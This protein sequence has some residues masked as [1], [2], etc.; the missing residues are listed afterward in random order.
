MTDEIDDAFDVLEQ[1]D[2]VDAA[3]DTIETSV[4]QETPTTGA[5]EID[6][7]VQQRD[8]PE[9]DHPDVR[10]ACRFCEQE[11][12]TI[13]AER[14]HHCHG[15]DTS[16][17][18][19]VDAGDVIDPGAH[20]FTGKFL[21]VPG[22]GD[23]RGNQ[24]GTAPYFAIVSQFDRCLDEGD[25]DEIGTLEAAGNSWVLN[26]G[27]DKVKFWK[28]SIGT[29]PTDSGDRY[30]EYNIGLVVPDSVREK[31]VNFQ[32]RIA[33]PNLTHY[34][35]G[36]PI[37]SLPDDLPEGVRVEISSSNIEPAETF[38][39]LRQLVDAMNIDPS[40]F[41]EDNL[42]QWSRVVNFALYVRIMRAISED[43]IVSR[44]GL[45]DRLSSF[46]SVRSG[47]GEYKWD[48]EEIIGHRNAAAFNPTSLEK[49]YSN[50]RVGKLLK[51]YHPKNP[52]SQGSSDPLSHPKLEVQ[53]STEY[54]DDNTVP[55]SDPD[56]FDFQDLRHELDEFLIFALN[57]AG[58]P[59]EADHETY[60]GD[61]YWSVETA[62]RGI[63]VHADKTDDVREHEE[64][65]ATYLLASDEI[66]PSQRAVLQAIADG[67][68]QMDRHEIAA[69]SDTST[70]TVQRTYEACAGVIE[71]VGRGMYYLADDVVREKIS[72]LLNGLESATEW[73]E[74]GIDAI[75]ENNAEIDEN[76]PIRRWA[77]NHGV[78]FNEDYSGNI[79][80]D[81]AGPRGLVEIRRLL[82]AGLEAA[83]ST[84]SKTAA[85][86][87]DSTVIFRDL[88][89]D[90][91]ERRAFT[92]VGAGM[93]ILGAED[94]DR[95]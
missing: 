21:F 24:D 55:W 56:Q 16:T 4:E 23:L 95:V 65:R 75:A 68:R 14:R 42:H 48:N 84:G 52:R 26:H 8:G 27:D 1:A 40:Y 13:V 91:R 79:E 76:S 80:L 32:F 6:G 34:E 57:S 89:G 67:G 72:Q 87:A 71:R 46:S 38:E 82:R 73:V 59:L 64:D 29:R 63:S 11:F 3:D 12:R 50:H 58:L 33:A 7:S 10:S 25:G 81:I 74:Q 86:F 62:Q 49:F 93:K 22:L 15:R 51:S 39:V 28:G 60:V 37:G 90:R 31:K 70:S 88:D 30:Y 47:R 78:R 5:D 69:E 20:E 92:R 35:S 54:S 66:T 36:D 94:V 2:R 61:E 44:D 77:R 41:R 17:M 53:F 85:K 83:R 43:K 19:A 18:N 45:L 9:P